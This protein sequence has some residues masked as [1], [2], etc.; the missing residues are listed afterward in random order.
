MIRRLRRQSWSSA[1]DAQ[2]HFGILRVPWPQTAPPAVQ[3]SSNQSRQDGPCRRS[4][5]QQ[6]TGGP[7]RAPTHLC[8]SDL[9]NQGKLG[10]RN[11]QVFSE[12]AG[13]QG[14]RRSSR[15]YARH[16]GT[17]TVS[18]LNK[19]HPQAE[20]DAFSNYGC[21][22]LVSPVLVHDG[23]LQGFAHVSSGSTARQSA[24][25]LLAWTTHVIVLRDS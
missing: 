10:S 4:Q 6:R 9:Q 25:G 17:T 11:L 24:Q 8:F 1:Q 3:A 7:P 5:H 15:S 14:M 23:I 19:S 13:A 22:L 20:S 2:A 12:A 18:G 16:A 21:H